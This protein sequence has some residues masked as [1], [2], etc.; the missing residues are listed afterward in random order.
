[1]CQTVCSLCT[2]DEPN[3]SRACIRVILNVRM[4]FC[5]LA[6]S[7]HKAEERRRR[8]ESRLSLFAFKAP[9]CFL[10]PATRLFG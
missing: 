7:V 4:P 10:S 8:N 1:M 2:T 6:I 9:G 5:A 3:K